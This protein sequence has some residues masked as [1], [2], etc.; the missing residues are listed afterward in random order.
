MFT[1][2]PAQWKKRPISQ[3][4]FLFVHRLETINLSPA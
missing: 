2:T 4:K 1:V 3:Q